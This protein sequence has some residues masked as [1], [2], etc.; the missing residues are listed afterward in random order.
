M[1]T[2][3]IWRIFLIVFALCALSFGVFTE[4]TEQRG[5]E[6]KKEIWEC[7]CQ[8][9]FHKINSYLTQSLT[10][11]WQS[12]KMLFAEPEPKKA[13]VTLQVIWKMTCDSAQRGWQCV[14]KLIEGKPKEKEQK[15]SVVDLFRFKTWSSL[16]FRR[17]KP[18]VEKTKQELLLYT[19]T[20]MWQS[21]WANAIK[22]AYTDLSELDYFGT[23]ALK[24]LIEMIIVA[25]LIRN[26]KFCLWVVKSFW[27]FLIKWSKLKSLHS[28]VWGVVRT[29]YKG[30]CDVIR[31]AS[32]KLQASTSRFAIRVLTEADSVIQLEF[33][34]LKE[35]NQAEISEFDK[36]LTD[37]QNH[38]KC[39]CSK[40]EA[41]L[42]MIPQLFED[43][44]TLKDKVQEEQKKHE[45]NLVFIYQHMGRIENSITNVQEV[46]EG[47]RDWIKEKDEL[48]GGLATELKRRTTCLSFDPHNKDSR[49]EQEHTAIPKSD[50]SLEFSSRYTTPST[51]KPTTP[52]PENL[53]EKISRPFLK[54]IPRSCK[55]S[56]SRPF[57][58]MKT[59]VVKPII[60]KSL[61]PVFNGPSPASGCPTEISRAGKKRQIKAP[62]NYV[63]K[64][65]TQQKA[66]L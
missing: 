62:T 54:P 12:M 56:I 47:D 46:V 24:W 14:K 8:T 22:S 13:N 30:F 52:S 35:S 25:Q 41:V 43:L 21:D 4:E 51:S 60:R 28:F 59:Q 49:P 42:D 48:I 39:R 7:K 17:Q 1:S 2:T 44:E 45:D 18:V 61:L 38:L 6:E 23:S 36:K 20:E 15:F 63:V 27:S 3:A 31:L 40:I 19:L 5:L 34:R 16:K 65:R 11:R 29:I 37:V 66:K 55:V 10:T 57:G 33:D 32:H 53:S 9:H 58:I 64:V 26:P 50:G